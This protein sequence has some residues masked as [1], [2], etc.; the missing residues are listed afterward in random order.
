MCEFTVSYGGK[1]VLEIYWD[2]TLQWILQPN[3]DKTEFKP[4]AKRACPGQGAKF[5]GSLTNFLRGLG[6][7]ELANPGSFANKYYVTAPTVFV[8]R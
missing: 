5:K 3:E 7:E 8:R 6:E 1:L 2:P 4:V